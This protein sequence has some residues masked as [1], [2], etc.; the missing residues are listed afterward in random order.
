MSLEYSLCIVVLLVLTRRV[1]SSFNTDQILWYCM[2]TCAMASNPVRIVFVAVFWS[3][4]SAGKREYKLGLLIP[5][6]TVL[7]HLD[8]NYNR[9]MLYASAMTI[10]VERLNSNP[11]LLADYNVTFVWK[12]TKCN[13]LIAVREQFNQINTSVK[14][15]IGPGCYCKT[16]ARNAAAFNMSIISYVSIFIYV[17]FQ[18]PLWLKSFSLMLCGSRFSL[19]ILTLHSKR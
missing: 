19:Y 6:S 7:P 17:A 2:F 18:C 3:L 4:C 14:A 13:E 16:A 1:K 9:G 11:T 12:D 10:A 5:Y 15:F 8:N